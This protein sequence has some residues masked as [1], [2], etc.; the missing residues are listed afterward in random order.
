MDA[1]HK[2]EPCTHPKN[3]EFENHTTYQEEEPKAPDQADEE[4][5][6][7]LIVDPPK[8]DLGDEIEGE[9]SYEEDQASNSASLED[10]D[11]VSHIS[12]QF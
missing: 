1:L 9:D 4:L 12:L 6:E 3:E 11:L 8:E 10:K 2:E 7:D 5:Q